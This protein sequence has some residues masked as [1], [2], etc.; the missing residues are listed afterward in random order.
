MPLSLDEWQEY[1]EL[2]FDELARERHE[3]GFPLFALEHNLSPEELQAIGTLLKA[4]LTANV[5]LSRHWLLW[6]IYAHGTGLR[7]RR[8]GILDFF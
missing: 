3:S 7:L 4:R 1:V 2:H 5:R 6:V 8:G